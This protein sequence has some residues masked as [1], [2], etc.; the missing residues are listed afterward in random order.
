MTYTQQTALDTITVYPDAM[1]PKSARIISRS[2]AVYLVGE[3]TLNLIERNITRYAHIK[4]WREPVKQK[5]E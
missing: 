2:M 4:A 5:G 1:A 3:R